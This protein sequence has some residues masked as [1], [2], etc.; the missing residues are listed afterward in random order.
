MF[1]PG[2]DVSVLSI[3]TS[4]NIKYLSNFEVDNVGTIIL[5]K[6]PPSRVDST[7][8]SKFIGSTTAWDFHAVVLPVLTSNGLRNWVEPPLLSSSVLNPSVEHDIVI[9]M[10]LSNSV[11]WESG[12]NIEWSIDMESEFLVKSFLSRS[13][14]FVKI[15]NFPSLVGTI[16]SLPE[17][18]RLSFN[19]FRSRNVKC[20]SI[21]DVDE[22]SIS[23]LEDLPPLRVGAPDLSF[24]AL[25]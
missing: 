18:T 13:I 21:F 5:E 20:S 10:S 25:S 14:M 16:V 3:N 24:V 12:H 19:I 11:H 15:D 6:L 17:N 1:G 4:L 9:S 2:N 8:D 7:G 23:I 22:V